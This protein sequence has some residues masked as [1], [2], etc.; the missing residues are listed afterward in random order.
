[1]GSKHFGMSS[2]WI[3]QNP[4]V[5]TAIQQYENCHGLVWPLSVL[6]EIRIPSRCLDGTLP[7]RKAFCFAE[8]QQPP[9]PIIPHQ[10]ELELPSWILFY[11]R[12]SQCKPD[13]QER[14]KSHGNESKNICGKGTIPC[15]MVKVDGT[16]PSM[17]TNAATNLN[18]KVLPSTFIQLCL[19]QGVVVS[20]KERAESLPSTT[21]KRAIAWK[22]D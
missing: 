2:A 5:L 18:G 7:M 13:I 21:S 19:S 8:E 15:P 22:K 1:M 4:G 9:A 16:I 12:E 20:E 17:S 10:P 14:P 6:S 11:S 3:H